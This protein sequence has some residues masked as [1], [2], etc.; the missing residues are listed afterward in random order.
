LT[1]KRTFCYDD[2]KVGWIIVASAFDVIT[3][4]V[5]RFICGVASAATAL[6]GI[7]FDSIFYTK[8]KI[9]LS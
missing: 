8:E 5:G 7:K 2:T 9:A 4:C 1:S 6:V 3:I